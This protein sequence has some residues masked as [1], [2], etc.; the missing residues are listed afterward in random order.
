MSK[1]THREEFMI[2]MER[3]VASLDVDAGDH[4]ARAD[5]SSEPGRRGYVTSGPGRLAVESFCRVA[6]RGPEVLDVGALD[7]SVHATIRTLAQLVEPLEGIRAIPEFENSPLGDAIL[8]FE[9]GAIE[10][11][12]HVLGVEEGAPLVATYR[13]VGAEFARLMLREGS[14]SK[15]EASVR[16][17]G[18]QG[19]MVTGETHEVALAIVNALRQARAGRSAGQA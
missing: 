11:T 7:L 15:P 5:I 8:A 17:L 1:K 19:V 13:A 3:H 4:I 6:G 18:N 10:A 14:G 2:A 16:D 9:F 12:Y